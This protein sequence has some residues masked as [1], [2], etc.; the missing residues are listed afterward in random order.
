MKLMEEKLVKGVCNHGDGTVSLT[1]MNQ[2]RELL[3]QRTNERDNLE[4][5]LRKCRDQ[6]SLDAARIKVCNLF[7]FIV[8]FRS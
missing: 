1:E 6:M 5:E 7:Y 2:L 8:S 4:L 3:L